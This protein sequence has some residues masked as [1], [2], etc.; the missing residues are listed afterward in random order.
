M[1]TA[2]DATVSVSAPNSNGFTVQAAGANKV[3]WITQPGTATAGSAI[4]GTPSGSPTVEVEDQYNN[5]VS[6]ATV[7]MAVTTGPGS[8]FASGSTTSVSSGSNG[9]SAFSNLIL[10]TAGTTYTITASDG[11]IHSAASSTFTVNASSTVASLAISTISSPQTAGTGFSVTVTAKDAYGNTVPSSDVTLTAH[12]FSF[13]S[14]ALSEDTNSSGVA[15]FSAQVIDTAGT[16][17]TISAADGSATATSNTFSVT[18]STNND[19]LVFVGQPQTTFAG[20]P[21]SSPV[22][23]QIEDQYGNNISTNGV[24]VTLGISSPGT[25]TSATSETTSLGLATFSPVTVG[26]AGLNLTLSANATNLTTGT[27]SA[28][29]VTVLVSNSLDVLQDPNATDPGYPS[30][31]SG[32]ASVAYYYC[33]N[34]N[35]SGSTT[36]TSSSSSW[37]AVNSPSTNSSKTSP[38]QVNWTTQPSDGDYEVVAVGTDNV[39]NSATSNPVYVTVDNTAP[40]ANITYPVASTTYGHNWTGSI[41]GTAS[42]A[43]SGIAS[44]AVAIENTTTGDWW[45]GTSFSATSATYET[46][47]NTTSW[48]YALAASGNLVSGDS[49]SVTAQAT[50]NAGNIGYS[51]AVAFTYNNSTTVSIGYPTNTTYGTNWTPTITGSASA[52]AKGATLSSSSVGVSIQKVGGD[53]WTGSGNTWTASCPTYVPATYSGGNWSL[54]L[55]SGDLT[56]GDSYTITAQATD[57]YGDVGTSSTVTFTYSTA[58]PTVS[59]SYPVT[60]T[61]YGPNWTS[62]IEGTSTANAPDTTITSTTVAVENTTTA[63]WWNGASFAATTQTFEPTSGTPANWT[64][65]MAASNLTNGDNYSVVGEAT[66]S[67]GNTGTN[68]AVTFTY[69]TT[70]PTVTMS[71]PVSGTTYGTNLTGDLAGTASGAHG[72]SISSVVLT[73]ENTTNSTYWNGTSFTST[74]TVNSTYS[75]PNWAYSSSALNSALIS[76]DHYSVTALATDSASNTNTVTN[77]FTYTTT[78]PTVTMSYPATGN[79]T[80]GT[81]WTGE[82][83]GTASGANGAT[84]SSVALTIENTS[85]TQYWN[86]SAFQSGPTTVNATY[87]SP[88]W[89]YSSSAR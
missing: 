16:G 30:T 38:Y 49:Y 35:W 1:L 68:T 14:G 53:C 82:L 44:T 58:A 85:T 19:Q 5:P 21:M 72:A 70:A 15:I 39:G 69:S 3:V 52:I 27:S 62:P 48:S 71:Y 36:C 18:A 42:D 57:S 79:P 24:S 66:D 37:T 56:S 10:D 17:Y 47:T 12:G 31:G 29:N 65:A 25:I 23:V 86:G 75:S 84:I 13:A 33:S 89:T 80:Y 46:A 43:T 6:G 67:A 40:T 28:F 81:N 83:A 60:G 55:P 9:Q 50:D 64:L 7:T 32:V 11:S 45:N 2:K 87:S 8:S 41:T 20:T 26:T 77:T 74:S 22:T 51:T 63:K 73:I 4:P 61:T 78:A 54:S 88:N 76:G 34:P 59:V